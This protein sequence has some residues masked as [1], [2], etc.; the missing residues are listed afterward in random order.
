MEL[1]RTSAGSMIYCQNHNVFTLNYYFV[2]IAF[3]P[4]SLQTFINELKKM[5]GKQNE[6]ELASMMLSAKGFRLNL[7]KEDLRALIYISEG[8][9]CAYN[10]LELA[11]S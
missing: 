2:S 9:F 10:A 7:T 4:K 11:V 1:I 6:N 8:G 5:N 3:Y